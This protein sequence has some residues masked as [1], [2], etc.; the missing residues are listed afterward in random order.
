M[1][2]KNK[3]KNLIWILVCSTLL[4]SCGNDESIPE[5][6]EQKEFP[7]KEVK[8]GL[9]REYYPG[10]D[11]VRIQGELTEDS[12]RTGRWSFFDESGREAS[13]TFFKDGKK[14]G[15]SYNTYANGATYYYGEYWED[16][17]IGVWKTYDTQGNLKEKD[18]G[19]PNGY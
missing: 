3:M 11:K 6:K 15:F 18:Y 1:K 10:T 12:L 9:Y 16:T 2:E 17:M 7:L 4:F 19:L 8:N 13:Y 5:E 14:H